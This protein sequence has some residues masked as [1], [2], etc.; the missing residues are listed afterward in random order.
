MAIRSR[1]GHLRAAAPRSRSCGAARSSTWTTWSRRSRPPGTA[2][3]WCASRP[4]GTGPGSS[5]PPSRGGMV[6]DRRRPR[7]RDEL[8]V[9]L[10]APTRARSCGSSTSTAPPTTASAARGPTSGSTTTRLEA[11]RLLTEWDTRVLGEATQLFSISGVVADRLARFN[12]LAAEPLYHPPPLFDSL[13]PGPFG[14]TVLLRDAARG[15]QAPG[16]DRRGARAQ[17]RPATRVAIA[18]RGSRARRARRDARS[19]SG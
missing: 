15:Q 16:A 2:P 17:P 6:P 10:R 18:G 4:S 11:Q 1:D 12:G 13:H 19:G 9:V 5:T 8:P 3:S 14:D 7:H